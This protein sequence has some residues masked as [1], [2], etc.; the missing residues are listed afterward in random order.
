MIGD[1]DVGIKSMVNSIVLSSLIKVTAVK[2]EFHLYDE[3]GAKSGKLF[4]N[5]ADIRK[6]G[7]LAIEETMMSSYRPGNYSYINNLHS[8]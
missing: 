2:I 1:F 5:G 4:E 7:L 6:M 8:F 3:I